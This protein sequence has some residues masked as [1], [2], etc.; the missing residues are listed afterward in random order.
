LA[1]IQAYL[2]I[3]IFMGYQRLRT[4]DEYWNTQP[5]NGAVFDLI[6]QSM[7]LKRWEQIHRFFYV[8]RPGYPNLRPFE[9]MT[10]LDDIIR[11]AS[12]T[13]MKSG[14]H[15]AVDE[16]IQGFQGRASEIVTIPSK[17]IPTGYKIWVK[18]SNGY[19]F[20]F[21]WH[22]RGTRNIDGPQGLN[23]KWQNQ[24]FSAT[25]AVVLELML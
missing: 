12:Q 6:R 9:K 3:A 23:P 8:N 2:G 10:P 24:G 14:T 5:Q 25:Q 16:C 18:A 7:S 15:I 11:T 13:Y 19:V 4:I 20:D 1:E 21:I 17:P 22:A